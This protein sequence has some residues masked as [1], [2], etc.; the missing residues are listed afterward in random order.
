MANYLQTGYIELEN[1][2][3]NTYTQTTISIYIKHIH[4]YNTYIH[5]CFHTKARETDRALP[6]RAAGRGSDP[7]ATS[8]S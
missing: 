4:T 7:P 5:T 8:L 2:I 6:P 1:Y 3:H